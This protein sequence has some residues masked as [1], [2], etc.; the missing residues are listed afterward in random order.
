MYKT[1]SIEIKCYRLIEY[2]KT[3]FKLSNNLY[4]R[5][6]YIIRQ[7][8]TGLKKDTPTINEQEVID[9][10]N[11]CIH[12]FNKLRKKTYLKS[13]T[14][15]SG[16]KEIKPLDK[17]H[18]Y[19][20]YNL[21][22]FVLKHT[23]DVD[24]RAL[25]IH[26]AQAVLKQL[27]DNYKSFFS[28]IKDYKAN[29]NKY[30]GRPKLPGYHK[31]GGYNTFRISNISSKIN[32]NILTLPKLQN[33]KT[34]YY[35]N[36]GDL[37]SKFSG[38]KYINSQIK[39]EYGKVI[40]K[41]AFEDSKQVEQL[42]DNNRYA[43]IDLGVDNII[44]LSNNIGIR[45]ILIKGNE[46]KS[47]NQYYNK[48]ISK[49]QSIC[50]SLNKSYTTKR[51]QNMYFKRYR[52][53]YH[54]FHKMGKYILN[55][56]IN[57]N[58][59]TIVIGKN[60]GWKQQIKLHKD[61]KQNFTYIPYNLLI[62]II[63]E[64][65]E[66]KGINVI[67]REESYTSKAS[68]LDLDDIPIYNKDKDTKYEFSGK[69]ICRGLYESE[70]GILNADINGSCNIIRKEYPTAFNSIDLKYLMNPQVIKVSQMA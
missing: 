26:T 24:Y 9:L 44:T 47:M 64:K 57:N 36:I 58:I 43:G 10:V 23:N 30:Q 3:L 21:L 38:Y 49:L 45:P 11:K 28:A 25:P 32:G 66:S 48:T 2:C 62:N 31:K 18:S 61:T 55:Y 4:N 41:I 27:C 20:G 39:I 60:D 29:P 69:R 6:N 42:P 7:L 63:K 12:E 68:L 50:T 54:A 8:L 70:K 16:F 33:D 14:D 35:L 5:A 22:D 56:L 13:H 67:V 1:V 15:L 46:I 17:D 34:K 40:I 53:F 51:I 37:S 52:C 59:N 65:C 19:I